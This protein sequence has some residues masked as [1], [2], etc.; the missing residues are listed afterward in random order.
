M[1]AVLMFVIRLSALLALGLSTAL[2]GDYRTSEPSFCGAGSGCEAVRR[3]GFGFIPIGDLV[4]LPMPLFGVI[5]F[6][7]LLSATLLPSAKLRRLLV[8][9]SAYTGGLAAV[10]LVL[11]QARIG[12][13][14][15]LCVSVDSL[16]VI[17]AA[18]TFA[19]GRR[20]FDELQSNGDSDLATWAWALLA[21]LG[22]GTPFFWSSLQPTP[23]VPGGILTLYRAGKINVVA[24][25]D[26]ECPHCRGLHPRLHALLEPYGERVNFV[27]MN[28]P[29]DSHEFA[30]GAAKSAICADELG[31]GEAMR[32]LLFGAEDLSP[33]AMRSAAQSL[34]V[35]LEK[36][37]RCMVADTTNQR[38]EHDIALL[39][40]A[41]FQ[42][43]PTTYIG[44]ERLVGFN[45]K[46]EFKFSE[47]IERAASGSKKASLPAAGYFGGAAALALLTA[48]LG[49]RFRAKERSAEPVV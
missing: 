18:A 30:R 38:I 2:F 14:C 12:A 7:V 24:F 32:K 33:P 15:S 27:F 13:F 35:D 8:P 22:F 28:R 6:S 20:G 25:A 47:A 9:A 31:Q 49:R 37:D 23:P 5:G 16:A 44:D 17:A 48:L 36:Y 4:V 10:G 40:Q 43:L 26:F 45:P 3:S 42:G 11:L 39:D 1:S 46:T 19:L 41:G 34:G 21:L 29:L